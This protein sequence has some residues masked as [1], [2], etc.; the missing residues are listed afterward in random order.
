MTSSCFWI[1]AHELGER[2][3]AR[4]LEGLVRQG[5]TTAGMSCSSREARAFVSSASGAR[6]SSSRLRQPIS[7]S[8][9]RRS[10]PRRDGLG[11]HQ[12]SRRACR[13]TGAG[14]LEVR[15]AIE[16][17]E[18]RGAVQADG[19][20]RAPVAPH[21][22]L[23]EHPPK[24]CSARRR[25]VRTLLRTMSPFERSAGTPRSARGTRA[26]G[27][28][29]CAPAKGLFRTVQTRGRRPRLL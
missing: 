27:R 29:G 26:A 16:G 19:H 14:R 15:S 24:R 23:L 20:P 25:E 11:S 3:R 22:P 9:S 21:G 1:D 7:P 8:T 10:R 13:L 12:V 5:A 28:S 4:L 18:P 6:D 17:A 2:R